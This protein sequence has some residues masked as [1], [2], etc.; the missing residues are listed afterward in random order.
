MRSLPAPEKK[1]HLIFSNFSGWNCL[2]PEELQEL[3]SWMNLS[4]LPGGSVVAVLFGTNTLSEQLYF[5]LKGNR[6]GLRRRKM[7]TG[8]FTLLGIKTPVYYYTPST[9]KKMSERYFLFRSQQPVGIVIPPGFLSHRT[10][11]FQ[12]FLCTLENG[13]QHFSFLAN[14]ADHY[15]IH[16]QKKG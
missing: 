3:F 10:R 9:I 16:L 6:Q 11:G 14:A 8:D 5:A 4:L 12:D 1:Y 15:L 2:K 7:T 13:L